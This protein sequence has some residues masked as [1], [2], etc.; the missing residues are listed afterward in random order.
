MSDAL[1]IRE[2]VVQEIIARLSATG[3]PS[4][5]IFRSR[6]DVLDADT[7]LPCWDVSAAKE[8]VSLSETPADHDCIAR[9]LTVL[10]RA[11]VADGG[12]GEAD[13]DPF[14]CFAVSALCD[15]ECTLG[16]LV[17]DIAEQG[18]E[19][20]FR[21]DGRSFIGLEMTFAVKFTTRRDD[22]AQK[23]Q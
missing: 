8:T 7:E 20:I 6:I 15:G 23:E 14:Y 17:Y 19:F 5:T 2:Q 21:P 11:V 12:N 3:T 18:S 10:V 9:A 4:T 13:L 16:N 22:P 1:S